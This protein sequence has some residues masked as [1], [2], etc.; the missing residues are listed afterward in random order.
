[1]T[2]IPYRP[3]SGTEGECF[4]FKWCDKCRYDQAHRINE[5]EP[6]CLILVKSMAFDIDHPD[7]PKDWVQDDSTR[8]EKCLSFQPELSTD[9]LVDAAN[10]ESGRQDPNAAI[11]DLF[12]VLAGNS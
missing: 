6:G 11:A 2:D 4:M 3:S 5:N 10:H 12:A 9:E 1:M 7:Y 8:V